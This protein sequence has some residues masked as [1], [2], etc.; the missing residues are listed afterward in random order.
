[1]D[2]LTKFMERHVIQSG[3]TVLGV[4]TLAFHEGQWWFGCYGKQLLVTDESFQMKERF[5]FDGSLGIVGIGKGQ[6]LIGQESGNKKEHG[7]KAVVAK[8]ELILETK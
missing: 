8:K 2:P 4:Q 5:D 6:F 7:G 3:Y 1:M